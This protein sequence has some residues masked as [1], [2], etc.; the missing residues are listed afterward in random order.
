M[1]TVELCR[2]ARQVTRLTLVCRDSASMGPNQDHRESGTTVPPVLPPLCRQPLRIKA[3]NGELSRVRIRSYR[4]W[5]HTC[6][7]G[8]T[9]RQSPCTRTAVSSILAGT[10]QM[11]HIDRDSGNFLS[12]NLLCYNTFGSVTLSY[13]GL[14]P[15]YSL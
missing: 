1:P 6:E 14:A 10:P 15:P 2:G 4:A 11:S 7:L 9:G 5:T 3:N 12:L 13:V 8:R